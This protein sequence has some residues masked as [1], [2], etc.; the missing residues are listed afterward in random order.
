MLWLYRLF[1]FRKMQYERAVGAEQDTQQI[2]LVSDD[3][4]IGIFITS[5]VTTL[6]AREVSFTST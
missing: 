5:V 6:K 2:E 3:W 1:T 4:P